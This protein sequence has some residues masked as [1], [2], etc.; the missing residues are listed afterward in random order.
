MADYLPSITID[1]A[2]DALADFLQPF[3]AASEIVRAQVN[4]TSMPT[5]DCVVLTELLSV[6]LA[7]PYVDLIAS[8]VAATGRQRFD[9][10]VDF[11]GASAGDQCRSVMN[12]FRTGW[13]FDSFPNGIK[14]LYTSDG[15]QSPLVSGE[16]QWVSRW[17][18]T[19]SLQYN[20]VVTLPQQSADELAPNTIDAA[21]LKKG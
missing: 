16:Q 17:T 21:D 4:R 12:A 6:D 11:Y 7:V 15:V 10:Q 20:P 9:V 2:I 14:P 19:V 3:A 13:G 1:T 8:G 5:G 18:L